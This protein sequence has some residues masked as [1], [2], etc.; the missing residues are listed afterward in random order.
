[1]KPAKFDYHAPSTV[2]EVVALLARG[3]EA[4]LLAGGQ[5]LVPLLNFRLS[6]P[7]ALIDL[8]P[9]S[10]L[11]YIREAGGH[12]HLGAMTRQR[13]IEFSPLARQRLPLLVEA[14][15]WVGHLPIRSRGTI[16]GS[17]AHADP[18]AE[19]PAVLTAL[20]GEVTARGPRGDRV[21]RADE[22][23]QSYL[24]TTLA[25]D[26]VLIEVRLPAMEPG[27]GFAFEE[28]SRRQGDFA[29]VGI[30]AM[31]AGDAAGRRCTTARL[32]A[33][34]AGPAPVRLREAEAILERDG[35]GEAPIDAAARRAAELVRPDADIH[36]SA[37]YRRNLARV[38]TGRALRRAV[39]RMG[40][41]GV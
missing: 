37:D 9:V 33:A 32:A 19:Y 12:V 30:A 11:A 20:E 39:A 35:L 31:V 21:I 40:G 16:G 14:T 7:T 23:F 13:A 5:S 34:G 10:S 2:E 36:A 1:M 22:L 28:F 29:I 17:L 18:A 27:A 25:A 15:R 24:M 4:K 8:N 41:S 3:G 6:R 38:L 26:E